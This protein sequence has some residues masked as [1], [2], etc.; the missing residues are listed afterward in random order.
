[1]SQEKKAQMNLENCRYFSFWWWT[2]SL[3]AHRSNALNRL[4]TAKNSGTVSF[5]TVAS[6]HC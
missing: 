4:P 5:L 1:M 3:R 6:Q 2:P